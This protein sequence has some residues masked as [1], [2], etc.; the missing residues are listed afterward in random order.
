MYL[1]YTCQSLGQWDKALNW[2]EDALDFYRSANCPLGI[3]RV[4]L[5]MNRLINKNNSQPIKEPITNVHLG[6]EASSA[7][8]AFCNLYLG[9]I[10]AIQDDWE[11][12]IK[13]FTD[14]TEAFSQLG[15]SASAL[16]C[17]IHWG[18][19]LRRIDPLNAQKILEQ[20]WTRS[21]EFKFPELAWRAAAALAELTRENG[22][23]L[24][25]L[26]YLEDAG[27]WLA[28]V[29]RR[30]SQP[31]LAISYLA[32]RLQLLERGLEVSLELD[33]PESALFFNDE[34]RSQ[35][36]AVQLQRISSPPAISDDLSGFEDYA[37]SLYT[38]RRELLAELN[39]LEHE[40]SAPNQIQLPFIISPQHAD[41]MQR[42]QE[43]ATAYED[44]CVQLERANPNIRLDPVDI[45]SVNLKTLQA[46]GNHFLS[47]HYLEKKMVILNVTPTTITVHQRNLSPLDQMA[48]KFCSSPTPQ[49]RALIYGQPRSPIT[50]PGLSRHWRQHLFELLIPQEAKEEFSPDKPLVI[51]P[52]DLLYGLPFHT[53]LDSTGRPLVEMAPIT[54]APSLALFQ[55]LAA[56]TNVQSLPDDSLVIGVRSFNGRR[57]ELPYARREA[58]TVAQSL[59]YPT[60]PLLDEEATEYGLMAKIGTEDR[61]R[62]YRLIH[63][64]THGFSGAQ[65]GRLAGIA[66]SD[67]DL[68]LDDLQSLGLYAP[69]V[70]LSACDTGLGIGQN[71]GNAGG[72]AGV[73]FAL[74]A[75]T[76]VAT[77]WALNDPITEKIMASFYAYLQNGFSPS[78][79]LANAQREMINIPPFYWAP[80]ACFGLP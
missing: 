63:L 28:F 74:G 35:C 44:I 57:P 52:H 15:M 3:I 72:V 30:L 26:E 56:Q 29:R 27:R 23:K 61:P 77:L 54:Y 2:L 68:R 73:F 8:L 50:N 14:S 60:V 17:R 43:T 71:G 32:D 78:L 25:E 4:Q 13:Y 16:E 80:L 1:S 19:A 70:V 64:A 38:R 10:A 48:L 40:L 6:K 79:A 41:L 36:L 49:E 37:S 18:N 55:I 31:G 46:S 58:I 7:D 45:N 34:T 51:V 76:V 22:N 5:D 65:Y 33:R 11:K 21:A 39:M 53:L 59:P 12:A 67:R 62:H 42:H 47:F 20:S 66:L 69:L 24:A 9:E 75:K